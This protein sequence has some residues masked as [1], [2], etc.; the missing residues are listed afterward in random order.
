ML[1]VCVCVCVNEY[2]SVTGYML[3][4]NTWAS[5]APVGW[6]PCSVYAVCVHVEKGAHCYCLQQ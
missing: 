3:F 2:M 5:Q 4:V 6:G 1:C